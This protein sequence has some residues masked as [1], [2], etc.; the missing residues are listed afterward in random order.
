MFIILSLIGGGLFPIIHSLFVNTFPSVFTITSPSM[1]PTLNVGDIVF[2]KRVNPSEI[3]ASPEKGDIIAIKG[4]QYYFEQNYSMDFLKLANNTPIIHRVVEKLWNSSDQQWL[5][6]TKGDAN[7]F[8]DGALY[9][10]NT[11]NSPDSCIIAYNA[12]S[13]IEIPE[14]QII[15]KVYFILPFIGFFK[16]YSPLFFGIFGGLFII[17]SILHWRKVEITIKIRRKDECGENKSGEHS[18]NK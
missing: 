8:I 5:F 3:F 18:K 16:I 10:L 12:S 4:P 1:V 13:A 17:F 9:Y 15:G 6:K 2:I 11:T 14:S 7:H